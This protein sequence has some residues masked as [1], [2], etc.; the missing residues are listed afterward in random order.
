MS[1]PVSGQADEVIARLSAAFER[2]A[3]I[4]LHR[5]PVKVRVEDGRLILEGRVEDIAARRRALALAGQIVQ[6]RWPIEDRLRRVPTEPTGDRQLRD[7]VVARLSTEPV[8]SRCTLR[9]RTDDKVETVHDGGPGACVIEVHVDDGA[10]VLSG[11]VGSLSHRRFAEALVWWT[12]GCETVDNRLEVTPPQED[13]D[14]EITDAVRI[15]LEKDPLVHAD[16]LRVGT[17]G[18]IVHMDG[19]V[20]NE[21]EKKYAV[22]DAWSVEGVW[23]VL[24]RIEV[25]G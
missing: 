19:L 6:D 4:N 1:E 2:D 18:G 12:S 13:T 23:D 11:S 15:V 3:W 16:Q 21:Q 14:D 20:G 17:A 24:D 22:L 7:E 25:Q 9:S 5:Y 8:F 10:V